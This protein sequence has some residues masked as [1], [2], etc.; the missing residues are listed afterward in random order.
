MQLAD[1]Y[2][3][4]CSQVSLKHPSE[5]TYRADTAV[6]SSDKKAHKASLM[7]DTICL[8]F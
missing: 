7:S 2:D 6:L 3:A 1:D 8:T 4:N 5:C